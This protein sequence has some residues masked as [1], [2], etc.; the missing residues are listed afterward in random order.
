MDELAPLLEELAKRLDVSVAVLWH[1]L[2]VQAPISATVGIV[3][4][5]LL[6]LANFGLFAA[7]VKLW[8]KYG[9]EENAEEYIVGI[10]TLLSISAF[11]LGGIFLIELNSNLEYIIAGY[12]NPEYWALHEILKQLK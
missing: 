8:Q 10:W 9:D 2:L 12:L 7:S 11:V 5:F 3:K 6:G 1:A 4:L